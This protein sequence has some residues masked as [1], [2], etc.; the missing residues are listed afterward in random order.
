MVDVQIA[1]AEKKKITV[2]NLRVLW[3]FVR[4]HRRTLSLGLTLGLIG[5]GAA[6]A[7]P[8]VAK[9]VL[10]G[11][12]TDSSLIMPVLILVGLLVVGSLVLYLQWI[13]LGVLAERVVLD[14]RK[15]IVRKYFGATVGSL[16][17]R[18]TGELVT[19]VTSDTVLLREATSNALVAI[20]NSVVGLVGALIL[21]AVLDLVLLGAIAV[22]I[23]AIAVL[24]ARLMPPIAVA[25]RQSQEAVGRLG[26]ILD[27]TLRAIRTVKSSR[28]EARESERV[29]SEARISAQHSVRAVKI[30]ALA[31]TFAGGGV[32]LAII[33]ILGLGGYRVSTGA[34]AVSSLIA[35]LLY[36][37]QVM[38]PVSTLATNITALQ[39][40]MAAA[41]RIRQI[42]DL[43]TE[44]GETASNRSEKT[45][46]PAPALEF[47][48][49]TARYAPGREPAVR[50][51]DL[52]VP[53][54]GHT[55]IVG[56]SGAGKTSVFSLILRFL[57]P[58][59]GEIRLGGTPYD[60]LTIDE[61][62]A[63]LSYVEQETPVLPGSIRENLLFSHPEA[64]EADI[65]AALESV[66]LD[67]AIR[68]LDEGLDT[69]LIG[70]TVSGGQRQRIALARAIV[71]R[72]EILLL[73]EATAQVDGRTE[74]AIHEVIR[75]IA[76]DSAVVTIAHRLSTV[77]DAD[78]ILVMEDGV[79]RARGT[80]SELMNT[81]S[82]YRELVAALRIGDNTA[83]TKPG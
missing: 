39:A 9:G 70:S 34:L 77:L 28:A 60:E 30:S 11:L 61:V 63:R 83:L 38:G 12:G 44:K 79:V 32:Q 15:S 33:G 48:S 54:R 55:A 37:F 4:P 58:E 67:S 3:Q 56:P 19:R 80:H 8:M 71:R 69:D 45:R 46:A 25:Q 43:V 41:A 31:W 29:I 40:G 72:P 42:D 35:F 23:I 21:M 22:A 62:R 26:G 18:P 82:L 5:T 66:H 59:A 7:T 16:G 17:T 52:E 24:F 57:T 13:V 73:D 50:G 6:L 65:W 76:T 49:V 78:T 53:A 36:A 2:P 51:M 81:D 74:A 10:D 27:G 1:T 47:R 75:S 68:A 14:A 20:V 64:S